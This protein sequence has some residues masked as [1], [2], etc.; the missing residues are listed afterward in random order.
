MK[1]PVSMNVE[2]SDRIK[3]LPPYLFAAIDA[4]K[5]KAKDKGMDIIDLGVGDPD[6]P[7]PSL[8]IESL[9]VAS[10]NK[11]NHQYPSYIGMLPFREA[12]A[13]WYQR[14]FSVDVDPVREALTLIGSKEG[15]A[16]V[17]LAFINQRDVVLVPDP[18]YPVYSVATT[19]AGGD[20]YTM[21]LK[22]ENG[23]FPDFSIIPP[24]ICSRA[25]LMFLNYPNNP[26]TAVA[27]KEFFERAIAFAKKHNIIICHDAA[28]TE[29]YFDNVRPISFLEIDGARDVGVEFHSLSK[30]FN[31]TGWRI[32][33]VVGNKDVIA[34]LGKVKTNID[35]GV[36]Q[37]V[38]EA[39]ITALD[40]DD[41]L[42]RGLRDIYQ[43]RR[44]ILVSGLESIG[45]NVY[46]TNATFYVWM[47]VPTSFT[48]ESLS[49]HLIE[50]TGIVATPGNGFGDSGEG[51]LRM[52]LCT[53]KERLAEAV[54]RMKTIGL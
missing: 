11:N 23:F 8:I 36:F 21:P 7:T 54:N 40:A 48:S 53:T 32:G 38:Q 1:E 46:P 28:Y 4:A 29:I 19:F 13:R 18:G 39:G 50:T 43:E 27:T 17:P 52:T 44:N 9:G 10:K 16:H 49:S 45:I 12:V 22:R 25:K 37:A 35:S 5:Q 30:T 14:R 6:L 24:D 33:S 34:G 42:V 15:I 3:N 51:Y 31:M 47:D 41:N 2:L 26:T 20:V